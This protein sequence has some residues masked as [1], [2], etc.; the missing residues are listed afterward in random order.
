MSQP[1]PGDVE[2]VTRVTGVQ[3]TSPYAKAGV[4]LRQA[5]TA[6]SAHVV[7]DVRP[8]GWVEF[9]T[10]S[11][12][13]GSTTYL[14]G[15]SQPAPTWLKLSRSGNTVTG[16]VSSNGTTWTTVG[17]TTTSIPTSA[18]IGL[19]VTSHDVNT[20]NTSTFAN[21]TVGT[22]SNPPPQPP[23]LPTPWTTQDV[24]TTG[25]TGSA[26]HSNGVFTVAGAGG[27]IWGPTDAFRY[28]SQTTPGDVQITARVTAIQNTN[29]WAKAGVMLRQSLTATSPHLLLDVT[30]GGTIE[31]LSRAAN[32]AETTVVAFGS[33][34][35]PAWLRL[36]RSGS[37]V[38]ASVS[39][40]GTTWTTVGSTTTTIPASA[41][42]GLAVTS[43]DVNTLNTSTFDSVAVSTPSNPPPPPPTATNVV[44]YA[45]DIPAAGRHGTWATASD[46]GSPS[47]V[48]LVSPN[49]AAPTVDTPL[50]SPTN[51]VDVTFNA[52]AGTPYR[53]WL[54]LKALNNDKLNDAVWVQFSDSLFN[55]AP[56]YRT[57][58]TSALLVNLATDGSAS[59]LNNWGWQNG[60]Y[61]LSQATTLTFQNSG[62][63]TIRIQIRED[64]VQFDQIVLS[65]ST[66][67]SSS[68]GSVTNDSFIVPKP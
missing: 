2:I 43:H 15:L 12:S 25:L 36:S 21:V 61:W 30:P 64:G 8:D 55:G 41:N 49:A 32:G 20:L 37:T 47:S 28:V 27:D 68:P 31:F 45:N 34:P 1:T 7:L 59:S 60:A 3:N 6:G 58:T 67:L 53:I 57:G 54:R 13:G 46:S 4:M 50:A 52:E 17:S 29:Q 24:G 22:P 23:G 39:S 44:I 9:M 35:V 56:I 63:H 11:A 14:A 38:T 48:K 62:P 16:S 5:L 10:R 40:N 33:Q 19:V 42:I 66:Y 26:S 18:N 51:Y 65:P